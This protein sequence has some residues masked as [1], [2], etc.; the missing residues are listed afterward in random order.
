MMFKTLI[1]TTC[2][3]EEVFQKHAELKIPLE[4]KDVMTCFTVD[5]ISSVG[6]GIESNTLKNPQSDFKKFAQLLMENMDNKTIASYLLSSL[7]QWLMVTYQTLFRILIKKYDFIQPPIEEFFKNVVTETVIYREKNNITRNDFL[8]LLLLLKNSSEHE[9]LNDPK[10]HKGSLSKLSMNELIAQCFL[11][12]AAGFETSSTALTFACYE[13]AR[14]PEIQEKL[15][16]EVHMILT[17]NEG[18][19]TYDII[20]KMSYLENVVNGKPYIHTYR[21]KIIE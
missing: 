19:L 4:I 20:S 3:L 9:D 8:H 17:R 1:D 15:R 7:P 5:V 21:S 12:F 2:G 16:D 18:S 14:N 11:F 6:L 13:L 10:E